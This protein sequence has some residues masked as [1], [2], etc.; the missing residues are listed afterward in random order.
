[1]RSEESLV[2]IGAG[3]GN[4]TLVSGLGSPHSTIGPHPLSQNDLIPTRLPDGIQGVIF[5][6][7]IPGA[8]QVMDGQYLW[9]YAPQMPYSQTAPP[10]T[11]STILHK[12]HKTPRCMLLQSEGIR[13]I[14]RGLTSV[15]C[16]KM[17][18]AGA[19]WTKWTVCEGIAHDQHI[20]ASAIGLRPFFTFHP[21]IDMPLEVVSSTKNRTIWQRPHKFTFVRP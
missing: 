6:R 20:T 5:I 7:K 3:E 1:M 12:S 13:V 9:K 16:L 8:A 2:N 18:G 21:S 15:T 19:A 10:I 11:L 17:E 14:D 4:R